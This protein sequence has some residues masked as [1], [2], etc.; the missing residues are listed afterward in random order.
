MMGG[1]K[2]IV[3]ILQSII[4]WDEMDT[5]E[6]KLNLEV[7]SWSNTAHVPQAIL[8]ILVGKAISDS[9]YRLKNDDLV[10][11]YLTIYLS[12]YLSF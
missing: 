4:K 2:V 11:I 8:L 10:S 1:I 5:A 7:K 9:V 6:D 3:N 12:I